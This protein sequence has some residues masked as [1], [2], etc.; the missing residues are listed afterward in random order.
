MAKKMHVKNVRSGVA[1]GKGHAA[2][3]PKRQVPKGGTD[4]QRSP[5]MMTKKLPRGGSMPC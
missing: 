4:P 5:G 1:D 3:K 2:P